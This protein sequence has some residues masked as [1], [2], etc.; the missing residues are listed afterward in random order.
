MMI[1]NDQ[2]QLPT[3]RSTQPRS[4]VSPSAL[5]PTPTPTRSISKTPRLLG[6]MSVFNNF[7]PF[8]KAI[9]AA[10]ATHTTVPSTFATLLQLLALS[11]SNLK[12]FNFR[13][14]ILKKTNQMEVLVWLK[15]AIHIPYSE[16]HNESDSRYQINDGTR[17]RRGGQV[18]AFKIGI[19]VA[20]YSVE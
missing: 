11:F 9:A 19:L 20:R 6:N 17:R 12:Q 16:S 2:K 4:H 14:P 15:V 1:Q 18:K 7:G 8:I 3:K 5:F 13:H 10:P